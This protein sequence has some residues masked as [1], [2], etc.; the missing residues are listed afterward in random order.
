VTPTAGLPLIGW[1]A[2]AS[3]LFFVE[4]VSVRSEPS[5][6]KTD[7]R[8]LQES[9]ERLLVETARLRK[10]LASCQ[11]GTLELT[12]ALA[13]ART[14]SELFEKRWR[15]TRLLLELV[16]TGAGPTEAGQMLRQLAESL[17]TRAQIELERDRLVAQVARLLSLADNHQRLDDELSR[18]R[19][20]VSDLSAKPREDVGP[21][22]GNAALTDAAVLDV[23]ASL[24][25]VVLNIGQEHG[26]R[27]GM[28]VEVW[29][30]D[31]AVASLKIVEVRRKVSGAIIVATVKG[32]RVAAGD[33]ARVTTN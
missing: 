19:E 31:R 33:T 26:A 18:A 7:V 10:D 28:P 24:Q 6:E 13:V 11:N 23:N 2:A 15:E 12:E 16:G 22:K 32:A 27:V 17:E 25:L 1:L 3:L 30:G 21:A 5:P 8:D 29:Q 14:E 4:S 20:L 9:V